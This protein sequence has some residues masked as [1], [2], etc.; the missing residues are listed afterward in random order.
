MGCERRRRKKSRISYTTF[1]AW[2][3]YISILPRLASQPASVHEKKYFANSIPDNP[4]SHFDPIPRGKRKPTTATAML[5]PSIHPHGKR[6]PPTASGSEERYS[7][8]SELVWYRWNIINGVLRGPWRWSIHRRCT[9][10]NAVSRFR[11]RWRLLLSSSRALMMMSEDAKNR[12]GFFSFSFSFFFHTR[13]DFVCFY[14]YGT[15]S[16]GRCIWAFFSS[17]LLFHTLR[18]YG[19]W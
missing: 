4:P 15:H 12:G 14:L 11:G 5:H 10:D 1:S 19:W 6:R 8:V 16:P 2:E 7:L 9:Y 13:G 18:I 3:M 17:P